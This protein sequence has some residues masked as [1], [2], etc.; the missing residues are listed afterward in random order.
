VLAAIPIESA[1][2]IAWFEEFVED[3][4]EGLGIAAGPV[5]GEVP[6]VEAAAFARRSDEF[7]GPAACSRAGENEN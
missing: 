4:V 1:L 5:G 2:Q 6:D 7:S 3:V